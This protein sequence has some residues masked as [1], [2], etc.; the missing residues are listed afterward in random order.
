MPEYE[1]HCEDHW[2]D[3]EYTLYL[4]AMTAGM[5][6]VAGRRVIEWLVDDDEGAKVP[7]VFIAGL[8]VGGALVFTAGRFIEKRSVVAPQVIEL[9]AE[10]AATKAYAAYLEG[11][12]N[13]G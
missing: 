4:V 11:H 6:A 3:D 13:E 12:T 10:L 5:A 1:D 7:L 8:L 2:W 9:E